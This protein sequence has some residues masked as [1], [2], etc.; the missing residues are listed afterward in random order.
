M[1][2]LAAFSIMTVAALTAMPLARRFGRNAGYPLSGAFLAALA[3]LLLLA[4]QA[5]TGSVSAEIPWLPALDVAI[6]LR[7]DGLSLLFA[8]LVLG[9]GALVMAY[10]ARYLSDDQGHGR[11]FLILTLFATAMLAL[12]LAADLVLLYVAWEATTICSFLLIGG[13]GRGR[14]QATRALVV[15]A[16]GGLALLMAVALVFFTIGSTSLE[17]VLDRADDIRDSP[18]APWIAALVMIA[19]FTKSAQFPFH[20]WLPDAMVAV[21]PVSA[22][23]HA[24]TLVKG[25]IY[26]L[27]RFSPVFAG[28][29]GWTVT[30]LTVGLVSA[31]YGALVAL[32]QHDLKALLAYSTVSQL[33]WIIALIGLGNS[34][35]LAVAALHTFA[36]ALFKATLFMLV[37]IIDREAGSRDIRELSGLYRVMPV[38]ATL[39]A[40]AALSMAGIPPFLGFVSKEEAYYAFSEYSVPPGIG[41]VLALTAVVAAT[42]TFAY[43]FRLL[44]GAFAGPLLQTRLY[45]PNWRFLAPA[46]IPAV[47]GL[48][49]GIG[50]SALNSLVDATVLVTLGQVAD[51]DLALWHGF[52]VPVVLSAVTIS[53]GIALFVQRDRVDRFLHR[54]ALPVR[55]RAVYDGIYGGVLA[56]GATIASPSRSSSPGAH[57][58]F[59]IGTLVVAGALVA[60]VVGFVGPELP[61]TAQ[62]I[63]IG[64][65]AVLAVGVVGLCLV[66]SRLAAIA[67]LGV[68]GLG[69]ALWFV[70]IGGIDLV[71]TQ[72]L[73]EVLTAVVAILVLR[74]MSPD[75]PRSSARRRAGAVVIAALAAVAAFAATYAFTGRRE[76]SP[77]AQFLLEQAP[78]LS[79]GT[80]VVNTILV[81]FRGLD[82]FGE[83]TVIAVAALSLLGALGARRPAPSALD[84]PAPRL[85]ALPLAAEQLGNA[86]PFHFAAVVLGPVVIALSLFLLWRGH[87]DPGGGFI[88][89]L[90]GGAGVALARLALSERR[91]SRLLSRPLLA[92]G[93]LVCVG[94]GLVG[95]IDGSFLRPL[96][97]TLVLG[98]FSQTLTTSLIFDVGIYL[99][100]LGLVVAALDRL[101]DRAVGQRLAPTEARR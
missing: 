40:L 33:G 81:D 43:G 23:L 26:L 45:E 44:W 36:H 19:A 64:V 68:V 51:S 1:L 76:I 78:E 72:V 58:I 8:V 87:N 74:R 60:P 7:M 15:T 22:Y 27:M 11:L 97:T 10:A 100:V 37:G 57:L 88:A 66:R 9:V 55:G 82:T 41:W 56:V 5:L 50:V 92:G 69:I 70:A 89:S 12:V 84:E 31:V 25:G 18:A 85:T 53:G 42:F 20:F 48:V 73:V 46:A 80:N 35:G 98:D 6:R 99:C 71:L 34:A 86:T 62:A 16:A 75:L 90:V 93:L 52:S 77:A 59:P 17:S 28:T 83:A 61:G 13:T 67:L 32:K 47:A 14:R 49:L 3:I 79:G 29:T 94:S 4:P 65:I 63:D 101:D 30:L 24:A 39:T 38:T 2:L 54:W 91:P 96:K 21:T 95:L